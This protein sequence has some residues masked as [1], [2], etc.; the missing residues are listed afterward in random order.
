MKESRNFSFSVRK[1]DEENTQLMQ[2]LQMH[3]IR[4]G[5]KLS[6]MVLEGLKLYKAREESNG[7]ALS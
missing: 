3:S 7:K 2:D 6:H 5:V 4:S 1:R